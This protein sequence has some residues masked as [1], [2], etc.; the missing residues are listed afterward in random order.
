MERRAGSEGTIRTTLWRLSPGAPDL[1]S[2]RK[3]FE[4]A[5][6]CLPAFPYRGRIGRWPPVAQRSMR[7]LPAVP[8]EANS[9]R[10][11][12]LGVADLLVAAATMA[13]CGFTATCVP[14]GYTLPRDRGATMGNASPVP[15][16]L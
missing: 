6:T 2:R 1:S 3:W 4:S 8:A 7:A 9:R 14:L 11:Q 10:H 15:Y 16:G 13:Q 5:P 12:A